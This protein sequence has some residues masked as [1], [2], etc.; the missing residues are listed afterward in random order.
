MSEGE[1]RV[2]S[3]GKPVW[4]VNE[5]VVRGVIRPLWLFVCSLLLPTKEAR[6]V[7][8]FVHSLLHIQSPDSV[9]D[10]WWTLNKYT[11]SE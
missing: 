5:G 3:G 4:E 2:E 7:I 9:P 8:C 10:T 6:K 11:L 1:S